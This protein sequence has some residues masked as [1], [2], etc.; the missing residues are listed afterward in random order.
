MPGVEFDTTFNCF[1]PCSFW[2]SV[3][4]EL[5]SSL[6]SR[7]Q[8]AQWR[9][10]RVCPLYIY[11]LSNAHTHTKKNTYCVVFGY[12]VPPRCSRRRLRDRIKPVSADDGLDRFR[13]ADPNAGWYKYIYLQATSYICTKRDAAPSAHYTHTA[14]ERSCAFF[15]SVYLFLKLE[16]LFC[17]CMPCIQHDFGFCSKPTKI[18]KRHL[19]QPAITL[20][21]KC[22]RTLNQNNT[23]ERLN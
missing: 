8:T 16:A 6:K 15:F 13:N 10:K 17:V 9:Y 19:R 11:M 7:A 18:T 14:L 3:Q 2:W 1:H 23:D 5:Y 20:M 12:S 4:F 21:A 22:V